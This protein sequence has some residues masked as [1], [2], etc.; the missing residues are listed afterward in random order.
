MATQPHQSSK[1]ILQREAQ[2]AKGKMER[3]PKTKRAGAAAPVRAGT[4][5]ELDFDAAVQLLHLSGI[6]ASSGTPRARPVVPSGSSFFS[7]LPSAV[8]PA[9]GAV[10][11]GGCVDWEE[12]EENEVAGSQRR[13]KRYRSIT[14][15]YAATEAHRQPPEEQE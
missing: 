6:S 5:T 1:K 8:A 4:F 7:S 9:P 12:D 13:M 14:E 11:L 3:K 10:F 15:I 2:P